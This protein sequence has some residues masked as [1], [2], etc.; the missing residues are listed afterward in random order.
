LLATGVVGR[1]VFHDMAMPAA[2]PVVYLLD[3]EEIVFR[4][5]SGHK[6]VAATVHQVVAFEVDE[7]DREARTGWSVL[8]VGQAYEVTDRRRLADLATRIPSAWV[9]DR[10]RHV[11]AI[12]LQRLTGRRLCV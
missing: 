12:P 4:T 10:D 5:W 9:A 3:G 11:V 6:L 7:I 2:H 1:V 8:G